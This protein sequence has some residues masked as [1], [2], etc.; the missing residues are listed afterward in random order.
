V[1]TIADDLLQNQGKQFIEMMERIADIRFQKEEQAK[2]DVAEQGGMFDDD[3]E[4]DNEE[5]YDD[6]EPEDSEEDEV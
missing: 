3:Y 1:L 6:E 2:R 5:Y 4:D